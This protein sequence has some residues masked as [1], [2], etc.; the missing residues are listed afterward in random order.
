MLTNYHTHTTF[1]DGKDSA[2]DVVK[3][4]IEKGFDAIGFSG[5]AFTSFDLSYCMQSITDYIA[6]INR[7]KEKY[8]GKI[9]IYLGI[10][11][12]IF[13]HVN[14]NN[15]DYLLGSS[16]YIKTKSGIFPI[17]VGHDH[18]NTLLE[19]FNGDRLALAKAYY[20]GLTEYV[21]TR[22]P[23]IVGH[24]DLITKYDEQD[25]L[26]FLSNPEYNKL[27]ETYLLQALKSQCIFELNTGAIAR[28]YRTSPYPALNLLHLMHKN[29]GKIM[30]NTD[31]HN[32]ENLDCFVLESRKIL[33][34]VGFEYVYVLYDGEF[35]KDYL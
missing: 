29:D 5:H 15:Y 1:C 28:G 20:D 6:E 27:A 11:E 31:C 24:F 3:T 19:A 9:Q 7:L 35:K 33:K 21:L 17:D 30:I 32:K 18:F 22:K 2:E 26:A 12:D 23:D 4:A 13:E 34:D 25:G 8:K 10:E 14:R 16:H